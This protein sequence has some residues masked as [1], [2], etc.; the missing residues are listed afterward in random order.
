M[1]DGPTV[2]LIGQDEAAR[3]LVR[4]GEQ[5][6]PLVERESR[7]LGDHVAGRVRGEVPVLTGTLAASVEVVDVDDGW[8]V[9]I[10][11]DLDYAGWIEFGGSRGRA[12][13]PE[14]RY[15]YPTALEAED[16]YLRLAADIA[17]DSVGRFA[18]STP[19]V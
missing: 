10:G 8:G 14:G 19:S 12:L 15:L 17:E 9:A 1:P 11:E 3:D 4:W 13:V 18:W 7:Q 6:G 5:L 16:D 2:K